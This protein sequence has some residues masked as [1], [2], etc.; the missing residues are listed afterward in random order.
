MPVAARIV[1]LSAFAVAVCC[2]ALLFAASV[3][4]ELLEA[5]AHSVAAGKVSSRRFMYPSSLDLT[6][7]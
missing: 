2:G 5:P 1:A 4:V 3:P 6:R 7:L